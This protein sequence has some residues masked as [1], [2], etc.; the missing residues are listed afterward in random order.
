MSLSQFVTNL[1]QLASKKKT[2]FLKFEEF[3]NK[4]GSIVLERF[5]MIY[6][7]AKYQDGLKKSGLTVLFFFWIVVLGFLKSSKMH[8]RTN[9]KRKNTSNIKTLKKVQWEN[10][11]QYFLFK[12]ITKSCHNM[13][14][15]SFGPSFIDTRN[16]LFDDL[17]IFG[18][19]FWAISDFFSSETFEPSFNFSLRR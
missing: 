4:L 12:L 19:Y 10:L 5:E 17:F 16:I 8:F 1:M 6:N 11:S 15:F 2:I 9:L 3:K 7:L 18:R 14:I 13:T